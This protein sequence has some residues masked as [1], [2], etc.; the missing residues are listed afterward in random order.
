MLVRVIV[1][2]RKW[3]FLLSFQHY[4]ICMANVLLIELP[5]HTVHQNEEHDIQFSASWDVSCHEWQVHTIF[6]WP[7]IIF[8]SRHIEAKAT[9]LKT[10]R[11]DLWFWCGFV[12]KSGKAYSRMLSV[13]TQRSNNMCVYQFG[14]AWYDPTV[15]AL[16]AWC[17]HRKDDSCMVFLWKSYRS[18]DLRGLWYLVLIFSAD[19]G[20]RVYLGMCLVF[21]VPIK[22]VTSYH[23]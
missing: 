23:W 22:I 9:N 19:S 11:H 3:Y 14:F 10:N 20:Q 8:A 6:L 4:K 16:S 18:F 1:E 13:T 15:R 21:S 2:E 5:M 12:G 7:P 17:N